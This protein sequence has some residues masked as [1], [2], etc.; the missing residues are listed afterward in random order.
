VLRDRNEKGE[1][2]MGWK[3]AYERPFDG[4]IGEE[5]ETYPEEPTDPQVNILARALA[6]YISAYLLEEKDRTAQSIVLDILE[7]NAASVEPM[8][9]DECVAIA[10][11]V[12]VE[13]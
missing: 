3:F 4:V 8:S 1:R 12:G 9:R 13:V 7:A 6:H 10:R 2:K 5:S 11:A